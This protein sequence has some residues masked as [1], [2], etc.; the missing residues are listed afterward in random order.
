MKNIIPLFTRANGDS[1][2]VREGVFITARH[3][4]ASIIKL[5]PELCEKYVMRRIW[6]NDTVIKTYAWNSVIDTL[7]KCGVAERVINDILKEYIL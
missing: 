2:E 4:K 5:H 1:F 6:K 7:N 3:V